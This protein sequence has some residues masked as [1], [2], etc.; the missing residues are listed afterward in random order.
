MSEIINKQLRRYFGTKKEA[1]RKIHVTSTVMWT[2]IYEAVLVVL[3]LDLKQ[4]EKENSILYVCYLM[5]SVSHV[6]DSKLLTCVEILGFWIVRP[7]EFVHV[8]TGRPCRDRMTQSL[9]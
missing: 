6:S 2:E 7:P 9:M 3:D 8:V 1:Q 4:I 5:W